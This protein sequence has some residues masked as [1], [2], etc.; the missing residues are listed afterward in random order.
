MVYTDPV[1]GMETFVHSP[2]PDKGFSNNA[3][4]DWLAGLHK[5]LYEKLEKSATPIAQNFVRKAVEHDF[6]RWVKE[7][8][9]EFPIAVLAK[10]QSAKLGA[11][12]VVARLSAQT[13][14]K[15]KKNHPEL[16]KKDYQK[17]QDAVA[18]GDMYQQDANN[19]AFALEE[20]DG[21]VCVVK[22]TLDKDKLY[23]TSL[24]RLS[25]DEVKKDEIIQSLK[26]GRQKKGQ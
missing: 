14:E 22:A 23:L 11:K 8:D 3:G 24:R 7:P 21:V 18:H 6:E 15:Q 5:P 12:S 26:K 9:M 20:E 13:L 10:E 2:K 4:K 1:T 25:S 16:T 17:A 19:M